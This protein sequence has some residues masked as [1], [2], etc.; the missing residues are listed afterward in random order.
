MSYDFEAGFFAQQLARHGLKP[1]RILVIGCRSGVEPSALA[2][3]IPSHVVGVDVSFDGAA[4]LGPQ[5]SLVQGDARQLCFR[6]GVFDAVY[7]Y[8]V[9]EHVRDPARAVREMFRVLRPGGLALVGTPN[10]GRWV[11][12]L[13]GRAT[14][15]EKVVWNLQ[16]VWMRLRGRWANELGAHAGFREEELTALLRAAFPAVE[17]VGK[18]Y[19]RAKY[20]RWAS[21]IELILSSPRFSFLLPSVYCIGF[22]RVPR[23]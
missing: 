14:F 23:P 12:Y 21:L 10:K 13:G 5:V 18:S 3:R 4:G 1:S 15:R 9:I 16:D 11:G 17:P 2:G 22:K 7:C 8:H 20:E 6:Q 19:Y